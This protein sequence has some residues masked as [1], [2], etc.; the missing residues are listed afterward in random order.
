MILVEDVCSTEIEPRAEEVVK[1]SDHKALDVLDCRRPRRELRCESRL[2]L[3]PDM[4][5][6]SVEGLESR[7]QA[8]P[9]NSRGHG[10]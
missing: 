4:M 9:S 8:C 6:Q 3:F 5:A 2:C 1:P 10:G 7:R